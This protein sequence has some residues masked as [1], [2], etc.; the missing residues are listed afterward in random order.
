MSQPSDPAADA[1]PLSFGPGFATAGIQDFIAN[2]S[3]CYLNP[4][5]FFV[6]WHGVMT[7]VYRWMAGARAAPRC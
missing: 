3:K 4:V 5:R 7:L 1:L 2:A 6:S